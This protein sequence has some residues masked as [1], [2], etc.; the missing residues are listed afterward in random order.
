MKA[1]V[2]AAGLGLRMRPLTEHLPK[3]LVKVADVPLIDRA[4]DWLAASG[5][6]EAIVNS[7]YLAPMLEAHIANRRKPKIRLSF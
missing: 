5:I 3:P 6:D 4:L 1:M 2:M 7:H